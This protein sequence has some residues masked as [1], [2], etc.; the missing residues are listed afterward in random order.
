M[1]Y[2]Q[3]DPVFQWEETKEETKGVVLLI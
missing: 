1:N 3:S 2:S